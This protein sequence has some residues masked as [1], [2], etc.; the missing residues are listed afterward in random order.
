[1]GAQIVILRDYQVQAVQ[2]VLSAQ[3]KRVAIALATG[4]G[5]TCVAKEIAS[6][7]TRQGKRVVFVVPSI[8]LAHQAAATLQTRSILGSGRRP[9]WSAPITVSTIQSLCKRVDELQAA[10]PQVLIADEF[11]HAAAKSY[12]DLVALPW[13]RVVCLSAT[14][15]RADGLALSRAVDKVVFERDLN[16]GIENKHLCPYEIIRPSNAASLPL[17]TET[18]SYTRQDGAKRIAERISYDHTQRNELVAGLVREVIQ[19]KGRKHAIMFC[20]TVDHSQKM[21]ALL[22]DGWGWC[23]GDDRAGLERFKKGELKGIVSVQLI[24]EGFDFPP[25]DFLVVN[26]GI[27]AQSTGKIRWIQLLGRILRNSPGKSIA[28]ALD[29]TATGLPPIEYQS[30]ITGAEQEDEQEQVDPS[31]MTVLERLEQPTLLTLADLVDGLRTVK[32]GYAYWQDRLGTRMKLRPV[33]GE[34]SFH[35]LG[36]KWTIWRDESTR[37]WTGTDGH[38]KILPHLSL[39]QVEQFISP[40]S[41]TCSDSQPPTDKQAELLEKFGMNQSQISEMNRKQASD[42]IDHRI[43]TK[44]SEPATPKQVSFIKWKTR[45]DPGKITKTQARRIIA[46]IMARGK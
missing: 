32:A 5:K 22:G 23:S 34:S 6:H 44:E 28:Y 19:S 18:V 15:F 43:A 7:Y 46:T 27:N 26:G 3:E 4:L 31:E 33:Q 1:V 12:D 16:W 25:A 41:F 13:E 30:E 10:G 9:D 17:T 40:R 39:S 20:S 14:A 38:H 35:V 36:S 21:A 42:Y 2:A 45:K 8:E 29:L 37:L 24:L 11:H